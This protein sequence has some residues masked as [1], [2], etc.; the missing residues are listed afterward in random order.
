MKTLNK[1]K[2]LISGIIMI[3]MITLQLTGIMAQPTANDLCVKVIPVTV[4][5]TGCT[6]A[7]LANGTLAGATGVTD[8]T[9]T[10]TEDDDVWFSFVANA[11]SQN[12]AL[13]LQGSTSTATFDFVHQV[14]GR[15]ST[16]DT[17]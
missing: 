2:F 13:T 5:T 16:R 6:V 8:A 4:G 9:C 17:D 14:Y 10:G 12:I 1:L 11:T 15:T 3:I 7:N